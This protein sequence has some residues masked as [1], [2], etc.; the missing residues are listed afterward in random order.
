MLIAG[1]GMIVIT[2]LVPFL[3]RSQAKKML[4]A[5]APEGSKLA[6]SITAEAVWLQSPLATQ[7]LELSAFQKARVIGN[8][9]ILR[10]RGSTNYLALPARAFTPDAIATARD[11]IAA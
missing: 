1:L 9:L 5:A 3:L 2:A 7:T 6:T 11:N 4:R 10:F 8:T